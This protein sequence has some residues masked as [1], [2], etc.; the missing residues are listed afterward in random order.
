MFVDVQGYIGKIT[1]E[2]KIRMCNYIDCTILSTQ[3]LMHA[4]Q[5]PTMPLRFVVQAMFV[6]QLNTRR[7]IFSA[8]G[9]D[10][11][12]NRKPQNHDPTTTLGAIIQ[13]D[14][15]LRQVEQLKAAMNTTNSRI[16][17]LEKELGGMRK[18]LEEAE[19]TEKNIDSG[20]SQSFRV[21]SEQKIERG[22]IGS[23]SSASFLSVR[24]KEHKGAG[25]FSS[26]PESCESPQMAEKKLG[27]R[28]MEGLKS[29]F[30]VTN[31]VPRKKLE[32]NVVV[33]SEVD[34]DNKNI[35]TEKYETRGGG[36]VVV[37]KKDVTYRHP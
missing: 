35:A 3:V 27:R 37:I 34:G 31:L 10:G 25:S 26:D 36:D 23:V 4:V 6:E 24:K 14:A 32:R 28:L 9:G 18:R 13:R 29:A 21:R 17:M 5:N 7:S 16:Q 33:G 19:N 11:N 2:Q 8:A 30:R 15:A 22:Q 20:R 12:Q 1:E